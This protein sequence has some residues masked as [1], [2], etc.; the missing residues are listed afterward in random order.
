MTRLAQML[1]LLPQANTPCREAVVPIVR[2]EE[3]ASTEDLAL[4]VKATMLA[5][6]LTNAILLPGAGA[7]I[8]TCLLHET[9]KPPSPDSIMGISPDGCFCAGGER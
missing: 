8:G 1:T 9:C 7:W 3:F 4:H 5:Y 2:P 6:P